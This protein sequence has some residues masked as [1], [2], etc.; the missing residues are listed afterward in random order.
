MRLSFSNFPVSVELSKIKLSI[1]GNL[2]SIVKVWSTSPLTLLPAL[3]SIIKVYEPSGKVCPFFNS[4][5]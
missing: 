2:V 1:S 4:T 5:L 3:S